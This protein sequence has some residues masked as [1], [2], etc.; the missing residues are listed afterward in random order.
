M[1]ALVALGIKYPFVP[2]GLTIAII[3][4]AAGAAAYYDLKLRR[5]R[6]IRPL[7]LLWR[8]VFPYLLPALAIAAV[9]AYAFS[10]F[11]I[12]PYHPG[13]KELCHLHDPECQAN[14]DPV[15]NQIYSIIG[16]ALALVPALIYLAL[17]VWRRSVNRPYS[18][19]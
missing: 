7:D 8:F 9:V 18:V 2:V 13:S 1:H 19:Y 10:T 4:A 12:I 16:L 6:K 15:G 5:R 14:I 11:V 3:V 17:V